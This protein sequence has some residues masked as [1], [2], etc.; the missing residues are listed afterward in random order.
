MKSPLNKSII[1]ILF[2]PIFWA[3]IIT[4]QMTLIVPKTI[5]AD[6][7]T[8]V[9]FNSD[10]PL[11][12][13]FFSAP[14]S[15]GGAGNGNGF[16]VELGF[17]DAANAGSNF[18]GNWVPM[19]GQNSSNTAFSTTS[20]G[21]GFGDPGEL[22]GSYVFNTTITNTSTSL[23]LST[24]TPLV[25]RFYNA[26]LISNA[27][28]FNAVSMDLWTWKTPAIPA[29][30]PP[31]VEMSLTQ[32]NLEWQGGAPS[33]FKTTVAIVPEPATAALLIFGAAGL[34]GRRRRA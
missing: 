32:S 18:A 21:D 17:Y 6:P 19:T 5:G 11:L 23:P 26:L 1:A 34:L 25:L 30:L 13:D 3:I 15:N 2:R 27:T 8:R 16:A 28:Y 24:N 33:A 4:T 14:L 7:I 10:G 12:L 29:P 22:Y 20:I 31:T 9:N